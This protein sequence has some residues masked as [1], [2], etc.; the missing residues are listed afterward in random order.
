AWMGTSDVTASYDVRLATYQASI[1]LPFDILQQPLQHFQEQLPD[2]VLPS[3]W[4][5]AL[6]LFDA[7]LVLGGLVALTQHL[8]SRSRLS[9][10]VR[11]KLYARVL[12]GIGIACLVVLLRPQP[13][14]NPEM[15]TV[16]IPDDALVVTYSRTLGTP[17]KSVTAFTLEHT[18]SRQAQMFY[19]A[20]LAAD[21]WKLKSSKATDAGSGMYSSTS[22]FIKDSK[23]LEVGTAH[24]YETSVS[25]AQ[26]IASAEELAQVAGLP[27]SQVTSTQNLPGPLPLEPASLVTTHVT[28]T[29]L[30]GVSTVTDTTAPSAQRNACPPDWG[31]SS[32]PALVDRC[33]REKGTVTAR[34]FET[35]HQTAQALA[36]AHPPAPVPSVVAYS[37]PPPLL[38]PQ[39]E[40]SKSIR[41]VDW[42]TDLSGDSIVQ[43]MV[44]GGTSIWF[45]GSVPNADYTRWDSLYVISTPGNGEHMFSCTAGERTDIVIQSNPTLRTLVRFSFDGEGRYARTWTCPRAVK[46]LY[47][48]GIIKGGRSGL[49]ADGSKFEGLNS[50]VYFKTAT[51]EKGSFDMA[52]QVWH[53]DP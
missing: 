44:R 5:P 34:Q 51:G 24:G 43:C 6:P 47:I 27:E 37:S 31:S 45:D 22:L 49:E 23:V 7:L 41:S 42:A 29:S 30:S 10:E 19:Q 13:S 12:V 16:P 28:T 20:A 25:I 38:L 8:L 36:A 33:A 48:T 35:E 32:D 9:I 2:M 3:I 52:T 1:G 53:F 46:A 11:G 39:P 40:N 17:S 50:I 18:S 21:G 26:H 4:V 14:R 15:P